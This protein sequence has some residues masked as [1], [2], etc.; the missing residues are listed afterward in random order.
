MPMAMFQ[1]R[2]CLS[3]EGTPVIARLREL[4][5]DIVIIGVQSVLSVLLDWNGPGLRERFPMSGE[6]Y[7]LLIDRSVRTSLDED[8]L[9]WDGALMINPM[10]GRSIDQVLLTRIL[11][12]I[13]RWVTVY[14]DNIDG[15]MHDYTSARP[16]AWPDGDATNVGFIDLDRDGTAFDEDPEEIA[17]W[18]GW[19]YALAEQI[20]ERFGEGFIQIA[21]GRL[22]LDDPA[23]ARRVA[24]VVIQKFPRT[25]WDLPARQGLDS[26]IRTRQ[27]GWLVP[28]RGQYWN[29]YWAATATLDGQTE[30]RRYA[31]LLT[32]DFYE[33]NTTISDEFR[34]ADPDRVEFGAALGPL[35]ITRNGENELYSR[36]FESATISIEFNALGNTTALGVSPPR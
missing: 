27:P 5:P 6:L 16:W 7:D 18:P 24:G 13:S 12:V 29:F 36:D 31:S 10:R 2:W 9:M 25:V 23:M 35:T 14:P 3:D 19:Q 15:I 11:N 26:A 8:V 22:A 1:L 34:G 4:N 33:T 28:R 30:F 32:G 20:Q 17:A 21:N